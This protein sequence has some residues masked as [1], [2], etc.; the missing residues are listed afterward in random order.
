MRVPVVALSESGGRDNE[1]VPVVATES[2]AE[3]MSVYQ[4]LLSESETETRVR[5][6]VLRVLDRDN[7][8]CTRG[9]SQRVLRQRWKTI[10][11]PVAAFRV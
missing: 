2:E 8:K 4:W 6:A 7:A 11:V 5:V 9:C 10:S 1:R 3:T